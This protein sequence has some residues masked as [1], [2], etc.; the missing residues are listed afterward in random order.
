MIRRWAM[1][2][3]KINFKSPKWDL[4]K[5]VRPFSSSN[6]EKR[7]MGKFG[8]CWGRWWRD[9][10]CSN[11]YL[12]LQLRVFFHFPSFVSQTLVFPLVW[13]IFHQKLQKWPSLTVICCYDFNLAESVVY[14]L[15]VELFRDKYC[16]LTASRE[17]LDSY[18]DL[19]IYCVNRL[20]ST[21]FELMKLYD[22]LSQVR[23]RL[24]YSIT[25]LFGNRHLLSG[26]IVVNKIICGETKK[27]KKQ[28]MYR[29][30]SGNKMG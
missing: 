28:N 11:F 25:I 12:Y 5:P 29:N 24:F 17:C 19:M 1:L 30:M 6:M 22:I 21:K 8:S 13:N 2:S 9:T 15:K 27:A 4:K 26:G 10:L 7:K 14:L 20:F 3:R 18:T 16:L 23:G